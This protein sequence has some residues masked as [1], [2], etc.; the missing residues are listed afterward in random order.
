M[1]CHST[2]LFMIAGNLL[3]LFFS[4]DYMVWYFV[5]DTPIYPAHTEL[6]YT[7]IIFPASVLL[8][9]HGYP[10]TGWGK[11]IVYLVWW[12]IIYSAVEW[13]LSETGRIIYDH[14][15]SWLWSTLFD[16]MMF[17][18]LL[19]HQRNPLLA[20][21]MSILIVVALVYGFRVPMGTVL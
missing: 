20:Y 19:L 13:V 5:P 2:I 18:M 6:I 8:F 16:C 10:K 14:G 1:V 12:V 21:G 4:N 7:F 9:F 11:Q 17:P 15:W 3:H